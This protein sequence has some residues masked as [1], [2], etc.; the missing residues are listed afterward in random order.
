MSSNE[1][2]RYGRIQLD[3]PVPA[4]L[5]DFRVRIIEISL[6]GF[7]LLHE[8]RVSTIT[9]YELTFE[10]NGQVTSFLVKAARTSLWRLARSAEERSIYQSG[11]HILEASR[12]A[13]LLLREFV[14]ERVI[15]AIEE[16][17]ANA[18]GI[19]PLAAYMYQPGKGELYRCC[20]FIDGQW[21]KRE[22]ARSKQPPNGFT[23]SA[24]VDPVHVDLLCRTWETTTDEGRR[25]TQ[26]LAELSIS[27]GEGI[28]TRRYVP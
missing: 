23:I 21:R 26:L 28:P 27:K 9:P 18:R 8:A 4:R 5:G 1:R 2:R 17:K 13:Q 24:D 11:V 20:E 16:Q 14:A 10:R 6:A 19:P 12:E 22:T 7:R 15:R 3:Q 25:L